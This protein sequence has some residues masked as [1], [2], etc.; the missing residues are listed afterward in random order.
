MGWIGGTFMII[1]S[2]NIL[3][4]QDIRVI[5]RDPSYVPPRVAEIY[6]RLGCSAECGRCARTIKTIIDEA[7]AATLPVQE[8]AD[9][10][11]RTLECG[12]GAAAAVAG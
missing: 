10:D 8:L 11:A 12:H 5:A 2:C 3:S 4:D 6:S 1:C 9:L 7:A